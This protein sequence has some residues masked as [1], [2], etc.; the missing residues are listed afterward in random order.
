MRVAF[1][2]AAGRAARLAAVQAGRA[3]SEFFYGALELAAQG[4]AVEHFEVDPA[5]APPAAHALGRGLPRSL[6]P[7]KTS[8]PLIAAVGRICSR[9]R[10]FDCL[11]ATAGNLAHAAAFWRRAGRL[12]VPII[13]IQSGTLDYRHGWW[14][15]RFSAAL[16]RQTHTMLFGDAELEPFRRFFSLPAGGV[17]VNHFGVDTDFWQPVLAGAC[18]D[19]VL[20]VGND[21][22]RD[23]ATLLAA[24]PAIGA[25]IRIV[26]QQ[27]LPGPLPPNVTVIRGNWREASVSD[28]DLRELYRGAACVVVPVVD[29]L[30]PSG[31]SV[32]L[33]AMACG[34]AVVL[35]RF[36]G[37]WSARQARD[38]ENVLLAAVGDPADL[39]AK[40]RALLENPARAASLGAAASAMV[41]KE[42]TIEGY[43]RR[44][45]HLIAEACPGVA[46]E[47]APSPQ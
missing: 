26:T 46:S 39:A 33:Q 42:A 15:R 35:S 24:A 30:Q 16:L 34:K 13:G 32:T 10:E 17:S 25:P 19:Y 23:Y 41:R 20:S 22:R 5:T 8:A 21:G 9:W 1:L 12:R 38:G 14:R 36:P 3:P 40:T 47:R 43:A 2:Y 18:E 28:E 27:E 4:C 31:Q 7:V 6:L 37:L 29:T 45:A 44:L 11:I